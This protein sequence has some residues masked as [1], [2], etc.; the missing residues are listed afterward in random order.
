VQTRRD[1]PL[2][3]FVTTLNHQTEAMLQTVINSCESQ[4]CLS[5]GDQAPSTKDWIKR[6]LLASLHI[7]GLMSKVLG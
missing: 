7:I 4:A 2:K 6:R 1:E 5:L 3:A